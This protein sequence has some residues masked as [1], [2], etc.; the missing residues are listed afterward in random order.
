MLEDTITNS[1]Y[2]V[3]LDNRYRNEE[4]TKDVR[5]VITSQITG[6]EFM[7]L[8]NEQGAT[9]EAFIELAKQYDENGMGDYGCLFEGVDPAGMDEEMSAWLLGDRAN[10]DTTVI[11]DEEGLAYVL[12]YI[13]EN[14]P[15]WY[16][17]AKNT[18][19]SKA[20]EEYLTSLTDSMTVEEN[21]ASLAYLKIESSEEE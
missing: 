14:E 18:L 7:A 11:T 15:V 9:E 16:L 12:Y 2:V 21:K 19:T 10:G 8:W 20:L 1:Y 17:T 6:D 5:V 13:G 4:P 3:S